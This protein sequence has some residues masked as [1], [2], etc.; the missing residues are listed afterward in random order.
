LAQRRFP[1]PKTDDMPPAHTASDV[2]SPAI[3]ARDRKDAILEAATRSF[4]SQG[5]QGSRLRDIAAAAD[6]SLTLLSHYFGSK[7]MLLDAVVEAHHVVCRSGLSP[8]RSLVKGRRDDLA[9]G[10]LVDTWIDYEFALY[11]TPSRVHFLHLLMRLHEDPE[12]DAGTRRGLHCAE[13]LVIEGLRKIRPDLH[14]ELIEGAWLLASASVYAAIVN[15]Q[16][17][18]EF[19]QEPADLLAPQRT[20]RFVIAGLRAF[21]DS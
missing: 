21:L 15:V 13:S 16:A 18:T 11:D 9:L 1:E 3:P 2:V 6:V 8:L 10:V 7:S 14:E 19:L 20:N 17:L 5:V 4:A 12:V